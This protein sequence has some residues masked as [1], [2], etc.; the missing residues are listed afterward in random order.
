MLISVRDEALHS[1]YLQRPI[2]L[3]VLLPPGY[4][5][6]AAAP[7]P[8]LYLNDG[9]DLWR[10]R[11]PATL[12]W[13]FRH[14]VL[15]PFVLVAVHA[16]NRIQEYGTAG[17]PDY[18]GRGSRAAHYSAF[19]QH[20]L[21]PYVQQHYH[22]S[23]D[24]S[25][26][27][28]AGFS[29]GGLAAFDFVWHHPEVATRAGAFSP[30]FWWRRR[31]FEDGYTDTDRIMHSLVRASHPHPAHRF[32]LQTGTLDE[33]ND[34]NHNG[35]IDAIEDTLDLM[36][37][38]VRQGLPDA[39]IRYVEIAGGHHNQQT[40]G[41]ILPD[42][43]CWA[44]G[45]PGTEPRG[46]LH[47]V[48]LDELPQ[49][50]HSRR[51]LAEHRRRPVYSRPLPHRMLLS[52]PMSTPLE[53]P[54]AGQYAPYYDTYIRRVPEAAD[55]LA[56]LRQQP[57]QLKQ[58]L[59]EL[60]DEQAGFSY[61]PGKW[62]IKEMLVHINDTERIFAYRALR[63]ARGDQQALPGFEQDDYVSASGANE[64]TLADILAEYDTVRAATLSLL[65]SF[66][67]EAFDRLGTASG[68]PVSVR[69]MAYIL[70]GHEAHH[71]HILQE[72][73]LPLLAA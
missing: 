15:Q 31:A 44:F 41:R 61:A 5:T 45:N 67:P 25:Q 43:L 59:A 24:P 3:E 70:A 33:T 37:T 57:A 52:A 51:R 16:H 28:W 55:P 58:L 50:A 23:A 32:W 29:L 22:V 10:L 47:N 30:S 17:H 63:I 68:Q 62:T 64:R 56:Q 48:S 6:A 8:V 11:L 72:R 60:T 21:L 69:A 9:Q 26:V 71:L 34:R 49:L 18:L 4:T 12:R 1:I 66:R 19:V 36:A 40:W 14:G 39:S 46:L 27:V 13:L 42:F 65:T 73:Y 35:I 38:L 20:E 53:R 54:T 7:Y 2:R